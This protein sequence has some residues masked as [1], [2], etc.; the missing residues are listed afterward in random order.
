MSAYVVDPK[1]INRVLTY[2]DKECV[3]CLQPEFGR[4][5]EEI[6][7]SVNDLRGLGQAMYDLNIKAVQQRYPNAGQLPGSYHDD[8]LLEYKW[9]PTECSGAQALLSLSCWKYQCSEGDVPDSKLYQIMEGIVEPI[10]YYIVRQSPEF[11]EAE[12]A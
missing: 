7:L 9:K 6:G 3:R 12:W 4:K 2:L 8:S 1:T 11:K 5:L 10:A